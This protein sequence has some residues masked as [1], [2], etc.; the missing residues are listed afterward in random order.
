MGFPAK[1]LVNATLKVGSSAVYPDGSIEKSEFITIPFKARAFRDQAH[2][3]IRDKSGDTVDYLPS[4]GGDILF[5]FQIPYIFVKSGTWTF[6]VDA[7]AGDDGNTCLFAGSVT[8]WLEGGLDND[9][10]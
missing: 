9:E 4:S 7:R 10:E 3:L 8:Q 2:L 6:T 1:E 5:D